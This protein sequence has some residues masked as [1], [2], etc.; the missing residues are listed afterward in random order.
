MHD[1]PV[2]SL[3]TTARDQ[4]RLPD[5]INVLFQTTLE[6]SVTVPFHTLLALD[7]LSNGLATVVAT[8][9]PVKLPFAPLDG[10]NHAPE[11]TPATIDPFHVAP[12]AVA[13]VNVP[14]AK[15]CPE[16]EI[17]PAI[18]ADVLYP[19]NVMIPFEEIDALQAPFVE[20]DKLPE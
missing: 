8:V 14:S 18:P 3:A 10:L 17:T 5:T 6:L 20:P 19:V 9:A 12:E 11:S 16:P 1:L 7:A 13:I 2:V 15:T 4:V